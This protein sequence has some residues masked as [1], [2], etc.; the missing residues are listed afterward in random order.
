M[1]HNRITVFASEMTHFLVIGFSLI[2]IASCSNSPEKEKTPPPKESPET[3]NGIKEKV[4][5]EE[6]PSP[7][8]STLPEEASSEK[9]KIEA[10]IASLRDLEGAT[11]IRNDKEHTVEESIEHLQKKWEWKKNQVKT[12]RDF[13]DKIASSSS[14][15]GKPYMIRF[16]DGSEI[17]AKDWFDQELQKLERED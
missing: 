17:K 1:E 6:Q 2:L 3:V 10:L 8:D 4:P 16:E 14:L 5:A 12:A 13:T 11:F 9:D 7:G 15:S